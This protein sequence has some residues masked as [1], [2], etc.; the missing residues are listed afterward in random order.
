MLIS[1]SHDFNLCS[2]SQETRF[3]WNVLKPFNTLVGRVLKIL[4]KLL[5]K[6]DVSFSDNV[7]ALFA[8]MLLNL[9][10]LLSKE[11]VHKSKKIDK[12]IILLYPVQLRGVLILLLLSRSRKENGVISH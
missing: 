7:L 5:Q 8:V 11:K 12:F 4:Q 3:L 1:S 2:D 10:S 9:T 6:G